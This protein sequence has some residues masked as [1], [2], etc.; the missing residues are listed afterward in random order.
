MSASS[1][2]TAEQLEVPEAFSPNEDLMYRLEAEQIMLNW[3]LIRLSVLKSYPHH[4]RLTEE[5]LTQIFTCLVTGE[6][7][8]WCLARIDVGNRKAEIKAIGLT[9]INRDKISGEIFFSIYSLYALAPV[10]MASWRK[11]LRKIKDY[12]K[13]F[14]CTQLLANTDNP[15]VIRL[16]KLLGGVTTV[17]SLQ[18]E[19]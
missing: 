19:L 18:L 9:T 1:T 5:I 7:T 13:S 11:C 3:P 14:G 8:C 6:M 2:V 10:S 4:L 15:R 17:H 12:A 16:V